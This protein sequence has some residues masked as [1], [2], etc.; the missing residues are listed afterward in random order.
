MDKQ[1]NL[2]FLF[3]HNHQFCLQVYMKKLYY[4]LQIILVLILLQAE[5]INAQIP[6]GDFESTCSK[7]VKNDTK[8]FI[9]CR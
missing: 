7:I 5:I 9:I 1:F 4:I 8:K 2:S 3:I 6:N